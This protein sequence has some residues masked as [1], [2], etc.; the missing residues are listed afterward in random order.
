MSVRLDS[1]RS[2][3]PPTSIGSL[4]AITLM[5]CWDALRVAC[6]FGSA[7]ASSSPASQPEGRSP[8]S[9]ARSSAAS[10]GSAWA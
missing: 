10:S 8:A 6:F 3:E 2:A 9:A 1:A 4:G 5:A 7:N